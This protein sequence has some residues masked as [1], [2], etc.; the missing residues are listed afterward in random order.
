MNL[1]AND[2]YFVI[3]CLYQKGVELWLYSYIIGWTWKY[4]CIMGS[5][6]GK[7][8]VLLISIF[9]HALLE[10]LSGQFFVAVL[11]NGVCGLIVYGDILKMLRTVRKH[12]HHSVHVPL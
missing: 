3:A 2:I 12:V 8:H 10:L 1:V 11:K 4:S 9:M 5:P 6:L 7:I